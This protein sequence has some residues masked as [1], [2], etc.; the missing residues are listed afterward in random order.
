[1]ARSDPTLPDANARR[2]R[3]FEA[4]SKLVAGHLKGPMK[5]R[6]FAEAK[7]LTRWPEVAGPE[8]AAIARPV[9]LKHGAGQGLG[10]TLVLLTLGANAPVLEM[11]KAEII[12]RVNA[13]YGYRAVARVQITQT[14]PVGFAEAQAAFAGK[15]A[16]KPQPDARAVAQADKAIARVGDEKLRTAL[17]RLARGV[18]TETKS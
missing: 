7:L 17:G 6:G 4:A 10:G 1:M 15:P 18:L 5:K 14:A 16:A 8:I 3:G 11:K 9:A 13:C 12:E 2:N